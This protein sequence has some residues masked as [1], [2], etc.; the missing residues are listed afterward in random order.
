MARGTYLLFLPGSFVQPHIAG[1]PMYLSPHMTNFDLKTESSRVPLVSRQTRTVGHPTSPPAWPCCCVPGQDLWSPLQRRKAGP[2]AFQNPHSADP[3]SGSAH[4]PCTVPCWDG[5][6]HPPEAVA[7]GVGTTPPSQL[8]R[9]VGPT[10]GVGI[11][12]GSAAVILG[13]GAAAVPPGTRPEAGSPRDRTVI[14]WGCSWLA[15]V[16]TGSLPS[17]ASRGPV[18]MQMVT[19]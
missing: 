1:Q 16:G 15:A 10:P 7:Q 8:P 13:K 14:F 17:R 6:G 5:V 2:R 4:S 19:Q 12:E 11:R 9:P 18:R 3:I